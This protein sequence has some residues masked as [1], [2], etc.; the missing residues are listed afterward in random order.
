MKWFIGFHVVKCARY[1][2]VHF[3]FEIN[4]RVSKKKCRNELHRLGKRSM[5]KIHSIIFTVSLCPPSFLV[6]STLFAS[7]SFANIFLRQRLIVRCSCLCHPYKCRQFVC[8]KKYNLHV[9]DCSCVYKIASG[10]YIASTRLEFRRLP[11]LNMNINVIREY[12]YEYA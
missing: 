12:E 8:R 6:T 3:N 5:H 7:S 1:E 2:V 10:L 4:R 9:F 11:L